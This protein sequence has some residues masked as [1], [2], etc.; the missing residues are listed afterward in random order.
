MQP[1]DSGIAILLG[2]TITQ[3]S[4][5]F[6]YALGRYIFKNYMFLSC[7]FETSFFLAGTL[8]TDTVTQPSRF[9]KFCPLNNTGF[10]RETDEPDLISYKF[11][12]TGSTAFLYK[13][14]ALVA[15]S[16]G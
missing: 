10:Y 1:S 15:V 7:I 11:L 2:A 4:P 14:K 3:M 5:Q 9:D 13:P 12:L 6:Y 16:G 8:P